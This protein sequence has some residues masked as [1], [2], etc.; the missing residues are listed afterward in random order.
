MRTAIVGVGN[1][2]MKDEGIGIHVAH[3]LQR[4]SL[5]RDVEVLDCGT[6]ID[7]GFLVEEYDRLIVIDAVR[8]GATPGT[9]YRFSL[10][11]IEQQQLPLL[12]VHGL[13][14]D[15]AFRAAKRRE[16][17]QEV[18]IIGVEPGVIG[19]GVEPTQE[20]RERIP[21]IVETVLQSIDPGGED[22]GK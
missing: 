3:A 15:Q 19:W 21:A 14:L 11:D 6:S 16:S 4:L 18:I 7:T 20:L 2:L 1:L 8:G 13:G 9:V 5:P 12:S 10:D 17:P 22:A